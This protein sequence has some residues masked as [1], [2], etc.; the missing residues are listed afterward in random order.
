MQKKQIINSRPKPC[1][2]YS[3][4]FPK[5]FLFSHKSCNLPATEVP[6]NI[7]ENAVESKILKKGTVTVNLIFYKQENVI[8][9]VY[10]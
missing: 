7:W 1:F 5:V 9:V 10:L 3:A 2:L 8:K 6:E 4:F